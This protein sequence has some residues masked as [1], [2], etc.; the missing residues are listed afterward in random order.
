MRFLETRRHAV[1]QC[2]K[3]AQH[4]SV[5]YHARCDTCV[6]DFTQRLFSPIQAMEQP[7]VVM[8][9]L[10][11]LA[12]PQEKEIPPFPLPWI[13][14]FLLSR[15]SLPHIAEEG[16][17]RQPASSVTY[18]PSRNYGMECYGQ[19]AEN[20]SCNGRDLITLIL[21]NDTET[22]FPQNV[23]VFADPIHC[24]EKVGLP[25]LISCAVDYELCHELKIDSPGLST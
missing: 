14:P 20:F 15:V 13:P 12:A 21:C 1:Y 6:S 23:F 19:F 2:F 22:Y 5:S 9:F 11:V 3:K 10:T 8:K 17:T 18:T 7:E 16:K 25:S 24:T 4:A